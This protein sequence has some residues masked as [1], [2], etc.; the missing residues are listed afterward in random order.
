[1]KKLIKL[2]LLAMML[3]TFALSACGTPGGGEEN[4]SSSAPVI[5]AEVVSVTATEGNVEVEDIYLDQHDFTAYFEI[6]VNGATVEVKEEYL[7]LTNLKKEAGT[8]VI[9]CN[10]KQES[11]SKQ[12]T[13]IHNDYSLSLSQSEITV[14]KAYALDYDY[15]AFFT[16]Q[17]NG[18]RVAITQDM[19][20]SNVSA[21][22]GVYTVKVTF[23]DKSETLTVN[24][25]NQHDI[26]VAVTYK[27]CKIAITELNNFDYTTLFSLFVDGK[28]VPV[29]TNMLDLTAL[30][31]VT[32]GK[33]VE[34]EFSYTLDDSTARKSAKVAV[35]S[36]SELVINAKNIQTYPN[37]GAIDLTS[38]FTITK[39]DQIIP[40]TQ[41]MISGSIDYS[42]AGD[43]TIT[44]TYGGKT[45]TAN[46]EVVIGVIISYKTADTIVILKG[47]NKQN[48]AFE[49]DFSVIING[50]RFTIISSY[51]DVSNVD[52]NTV[53]SYTAKLTIPYNES[54]LSLSGAK[55]DYYEKEITYQVVENEYELSVKEERVTLPK[56]TTSYNPFRNIDLTINGLMQT[57]TD[58]PAYVDRIS[59]YAKVI[60]TPIDFN[61]IAV[62]RVV[63][64]VYV[65]GV[66]ATPVT[67]EFDVIV[68]SDVVI[69]STNKVVFTDTT[70]MATDLFTV[71]KGGKQ[72]EVTFDMITGKID[73]FKPGVYTVE[74]DYLGLT[75]S[76]TVVVL[77]KEMQGTYRT[78]LYTIPDRYFDEEVTTKG[79][80]GPMS[81]SETGEI[82]IKGV[83]AEV[84]DA[85]DEKTIVFKY[86]SNIHTLYYENG[87]IVI[88]PDNA[89]KLN[90]YEDKRPYIYFNEK[91]WTISR[92]F[93]LNSTEN[94]V[95][96]NN[97]GSYSLD[98]FILEN[99]QTKEKLTYALKIHLVSKI[100]SDTVYELSWGEGAFAEGFSGQTGET[101]IFTMNG[102]SYSFTLS[103]PGTGKIARP[104]DAQK[105]YA[106]MT[107]R[108]TIDGQNATLS[109]DQYQAFTLR[110]GTTQIFKASSYEIASMTNGGVDYIKQEVMLYY[111]DVR[112]D[113]FYSYKFKVDPV[114][115]TFEYIAH[116]SL[117]GYYET[118]NAYVMF[119]GYGSGFIN[120]NSKSYATTDFTYS[121]LDNIVTITYKN[122]NSTFAYGK[123]AQ[124]S[125][126]FFGNKLTVHDGLG[127]TPSAVL[128]NRYI[129]SG[130]IVNVN[131]ETI[132]KATKT[133]AMPE[134]LRS[135]EIIT[136]DGALTDDQ[137]VSYLDTKKVDFTRAGFYQLTVNAEFYGEK[138]T[139]Y[140][141][142]QVL[143]KVNEGSPLISVYGAGVIYP[144]NSLI[145]DE[146][147][148]LTIA[149]DNGVYVGAIKIADNGFSAEV[150]GKNGTSSIEGELIANGLVRVRATGALS[151]IDYYTTGRAYI[152]GR[153]TTILRAFELSGGNVYILSQAETSA[154]GEIAQVEVL[155]GTAVMAVGSILKISTPSGETFVKIAEMGNVRTG[156]T[157][158]D[159][160]RGTFTGEGESLQLDGFGKAVY[161]STAG[162]YVLN[163][164]YKITVY[165]NNN[166]TVYQINL[167]NSTY[168]KIDVAF[169]S[170]LVAGKKF[171]A[172]LYFFCGEYMYLAT[173][174]FEFSA[175]GKVTV[176]S[177]SSEHDS[178]DES[179]VTDKYA[180]DFCPSGTAQ[181]TYGVNGTKVTVTVNGYTFVFNISNVVVVNE[182]VCEN[183]GGLQSDAHGYFAIGNTFT[184]VVAE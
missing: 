52:F 66:N 17:I 76:A 6:T 180:P 21:I 136:K 44:L 179:C 47:T 86:K 168:K 91:T 157:F 118:D 9:S 56:G 15:L 133:V 164:N 22:P 154:S 109:A 14:N 60:S 161:G 110:I 101:S 153:G 147:G 126:D 149:C 134:L 103:D 102:L 11:A 83:K 108:G 29:T 64:E 104:E 23:G 111:V 163:G 162:T 26:V 51:I 72:V 151:Y 45:A 28:A 89:I 58:N 117:L 113:T 173:T 122:V 10:Y 80:V 13:V 130:I 129:Q 155:S 24:V 123:S 148:R 42:K 92:K 75:E 27:V 78:N 93:V 85:I 160:H 7:D 43:N 159:G 4:S 125:V 181:G 88:D 138:I 38:L 31:G 184:Y 81:I 54:S 177:L 53:G 30:E 107:F 39:G 37:S 61:S 57:L 146:Y 115:K 119:D 137:K 169:D 135:I 176:T 40:V 3:V 62:Q 41:D 152:V 175:N 48:Y 25:T 71:T 144:Q 166:P 33:E 172:D 94:Y 19:V 143:D 12:V 34:I 121:K 67:V 87:I 8:Y 99:K 131:I 167:A 141:A 90:Y 106:G 69:T 98:V 124:F 140:Y 145:I 79:H 2:I 158:A 128:V 182:L 35:V 178:G 183:N 116:D 16:A 1:M 142:I 77:S 73:V 112:D 174:T 96:D 105:L 100:M 84:L 36:Q 46:V 18:E 68:Q 49:K 156:L 127:L 150:Y 55:F 139:A 132:G 170:T 120:F 59:C 50:V 171:T 5:P 82:T 95:L 20:E 165:L 32:V 74:I 97:Y 114:A 65:N 70:V 63:V